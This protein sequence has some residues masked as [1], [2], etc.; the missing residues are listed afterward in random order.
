M[1]KIKGVISKKFPRGQWA[2]AGDDGFI[3][4]DPKCKGR[5]DLEMVNHE[6]LHILCPWLAE[7]AVRIIG[8]ELTRIQWDRGYR[9][10]DADDSIELQ[11]EEHGLTDSLDILDKPDA[12]I[13]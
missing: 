2:E 6:G 10:I 12:E 13:K 8:A 7:D 4:I 9:R 5:K 3:Y 11:D 1:A